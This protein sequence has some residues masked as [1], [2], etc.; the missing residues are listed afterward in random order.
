MKNFKFNV[1]AVGGDNPHNIADINCNLGTITINTEKMIF[2]GGPNTNENRLFLI[3]GPLGNYA[4][5]YALI[6]GENCSDT[7]DEA[8]DLGLLDGLKIDEAERELDEGEGHYRL[9]NNGELYDINDVECREIMYNELPIL[10]YYIGMAAACQQ[11]DIPNAPKVITL[12]WL[13]DNI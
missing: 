5:N 1:R 8:A 4:F 10:C 11:L 12:Q 2:N 3:S 13:M 7:L 6:W 9:G